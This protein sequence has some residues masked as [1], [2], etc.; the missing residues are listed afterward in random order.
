VIEGF[1]PGV[2]K[3]LG[4]GP[5]EMTAANQRLIYCSLPGFGE[6]DPRASLPGWEGIICTAAG[7]YDP[8][9]LA[10][11]FKKEEPYYSAL[12]HASTF[13]ALMAAHGIV[14]ALIARESSGRGQWIEVPLFDACYEVI[15]IAGYRLILNFRTFESLC[16]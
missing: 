12:P 6:D 10:G 13:A 11:Y 16:S 15:G 14:A 8:P 1:R 7:L 3:R 2:M 4:L 9:S 5:L